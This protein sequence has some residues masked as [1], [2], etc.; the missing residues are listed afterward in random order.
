MQPDAVAEFITAYGQELNARRGT[1]GADRARR[2]GERAQIARKLSGLYDAI[3]EG[4]RTSGLKD[5]L[6]ELEAQLAALDEELATP[7]PSPVRLHPGLA[8][9]YHAR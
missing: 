9:T 7:T 3:A 8:E 2:Q 5:R 4:L 1:E 6:E